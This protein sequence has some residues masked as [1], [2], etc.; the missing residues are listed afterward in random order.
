MMDE[1]ENDNG[2]K[3]IKLNPDGDRDDMSVDDPLVSIVQKSQTLA[4]EDILEALYPLI[5]NVT[6]YDS[7][8]SLISDLKAT[9][10]LKVS[11]LAILEKQP[12][13][14][15]QEVWT[16]YKDAREREM[17]AKIQKRDEA[18][19]SKYL[20][21]AFELRNAILNSNLRNI[22]GNSEMEVYDRHVPDLQN[23][24]QLQKVVLRHA[25]KVFW[26]TCLTCSKVNHPVCGVGYPGIGK[27]TTTLY[28]LQKIIMEEQQPVVYTIRCEPSE[29]GI[30]Y[31]LSPVVEEGQVHDIEVILHMKFHNTMLSNSTL[32]NGRAFY[33]VDPGKFKGN[34]DNIGKIEARFIM[35]ASN[36]C[37]HWGGAEFAKDRSSDNDLFFQTTKPNELHGVFV[38]GHLWTASQVLAAKP[39]VA[40]LKNVNE[41][42]ILQRYRMFGGSIRDIKTMNE[43][44]FQKNALSALADI[45][46]GIINEL[47]EGRYKFAFKPDQPSSR[48]IGIGPEK[49]RP[50]N[51]YTVFLKSD[52]IQEL[53]AENWLHNSWYSVLDEDNGGNRGNLFEA[54]VRRKFYKQQV[55][56]ES[57]RI[58]ESHRE[59]PPNSRSVFKNYQ[60]VTAGRQVGSQRK[61][62][63]V[64]KLAKSVREDETKEFLYYSKDESEPL[65]DM[66]YRVDGG[67]E[68]IQATISL[69][70][71]AARNK[72]ED[73]KNALDLQSD[74]TLRIFY[75]V[76]SVKYAQFV[77]KPANPL[78]TDQH[79]FS[80]IFIYHLSIDDDCRDP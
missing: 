30:Y 18:F 47:I 68:A 11:E 40:S 49:D 71:D 26:D 79:D 59:R 53:L 70:H 58:R 21:T 12:D 33:V 37:T 19:F 61:V 48:I 54:F 36:D 10:F 5:L 77:T 57:D 69:E 45:K 43:K 3:K 55:H 17:N 46:D 72:I 9:G 28:L 27:T 31:E 56:F 6:P 80:N 7:T 63:R 39:Y 16:I 67:Y 4:D 75:A 44:A 8:S 74:Q 60:P 23:P 20:I 29:Q 62:R 1:E 76:P 38:Y 41:N 35:A 50:T 64:S 15:L 51:L 2:K 78:D 32:Q 13:A 73:L 65:I 42:V 66:I 34:C 25:D 14:I 22:E 24:G 52:Y